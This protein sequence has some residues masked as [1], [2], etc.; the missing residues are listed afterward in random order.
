[1]PK[2]LA[3]LRVTLAKLDGHD[4]FT[5][6]GLGALG[7]GLWLRFGLWAGLTAVGLVLVGFAWKGL[8]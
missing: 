1:M 6:G 4:G 3:A 5:F 2:P 7:I 8:R